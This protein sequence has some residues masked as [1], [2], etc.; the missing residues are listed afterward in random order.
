MNFRSIIGLTLCVST[1]AAWAWQDTPP[2]APSPPVPGI[3]QMQSTPPADLLNSPAVVENMPS[4]QR[5]HAWILPIADSLAP[6][7]AVTLLQKI[8]QSG[9][10][11]YSI[12]T[13]QLAVVY[14][15]PEIDQQRLQHWQNKLQKI[16]P[17]V[18]NIQAF[19]PLHQEVQ[20]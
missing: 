9:Y 11:A 20:S 13:G 2:P 15:G 5:S 19:D 14:V 3:T 18:G 4:Q 7:D 10:P 1:M 12:T 16:Y 6:G 17:N 8:R